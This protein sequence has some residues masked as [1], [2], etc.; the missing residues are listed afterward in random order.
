MR[1]NRWRIYFPCHIRFSIACLTYCLGK[2]Q[3]PNTRETLKVLGRQIGCVL[4]M[5]VAV[6]NKG[7]KSSLKFCGNGHNSKQHSCGATKMLDTGKLGKFRSDH[8]HFGSQKCNE[9]KQNKGFKVSQG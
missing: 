4:P 6:I 5:I 2:D 3:I 8:L 1:A 9:A 7:Q